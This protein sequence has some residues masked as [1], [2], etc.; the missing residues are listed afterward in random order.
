MGAW[1]ASISGNDR[2]LDIEAKA[3]EAC[4]L[5]LFDYCKDNSIL[6]AEL[7]N[8]H[9]DEILEIA[10]IR[11]LHHGLLALGFLIMKVGANIPKEVRIDILTEAELE[12][13]DWK[14][15]DPC[16]KLERIP[17]IQEFK[18]ALWN[19]RRGEKINLE[20]ISLIGLSFIREVIEPVLGEAMK[21]KASNEIIGFLQRLMCK[22]DI[23]LEELCSIFNIYSGEEYFTFFNTM[24]KFEEEYCSP[25]KKYRNEMTI[26]DLFLNR[27]VNNVKIEDVWLGKMNS[28]DSNDLEL[29]KADSGN[30]YIYKMRLC[31][32]HYI[33]QSIIPLQK[34]AAQHI[35]KFKIAP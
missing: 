10:K 12:L 9:F 2:Y 17:Y 34:R 33:G 1:S 15:D 22:L 24:I 25:I 13:V 23:P 31:D 27:I 19:C 3:V 4:G 30:Y 28:I 20:E 35:S 32:K 11:D 14:F 26:G 18:N 8:T 21:R 5:D 7:F 16:F 6:T 29:L